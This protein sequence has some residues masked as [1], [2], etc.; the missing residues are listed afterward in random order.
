MTDKPAQPTSI[1]D[2]WRHDGG[3]RPAVTRRRS[4]PD[5]VVRHSHEGG[6]IHEHTG[7]KLPHEHNS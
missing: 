2:R 7:G 6:L 4:G 1:V 5:A 3:Y